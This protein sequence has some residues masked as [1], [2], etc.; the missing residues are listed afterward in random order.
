MVLQRRIGATVIDL[1]ECDG[2]LSLSVASP[3][4]AA[5]DTNIERLMPF[6]AG[7]VGTKLVNLCVRQCCSLA[8]G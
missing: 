1:D 8:S 3:L 4:F 6:A 7:K 5:P 2:S